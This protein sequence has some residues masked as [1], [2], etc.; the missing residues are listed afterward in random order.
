MKCI[1]TQAALFIAWLVALFLDPQLPPLVLPVQWCMF[2]ML[3]LALTLPGGSK[4]K[5]YEAVC[6]ESAWS[7]L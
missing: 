4:R 1:W 7:S 2:E 6:L 5:I 3:M